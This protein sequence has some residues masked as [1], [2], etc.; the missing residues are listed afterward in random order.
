VLVG[1]NTYYYLIRRGSIMNSEYN[2]K[3]TDIVD[4]VYDRALWLD[5]IGQ[6]KLADETRLFVYSQVA[7]AYAHLDK[8][9]SSHVKRLREVKAI[10]DRCYG[11]LMNSGYI[12]KKQKLRLFILKHTPSLHTLLWGK[13][14]PI[15][16]GGE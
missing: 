13:K 16:L 15:N 10:Y 6:K 4:A 12:G 7:V 2:I 11:T 5:S 9:N 3:F 14:M 1:R 8:K